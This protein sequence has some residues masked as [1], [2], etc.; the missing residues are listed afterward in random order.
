MN[1][2]KLKEQARSVIH[3]AEKILALVNDFP[4]KDI[5]P[6]AKLWIGDKDKFTFDMLAHT[7]D[8]EDEWANLLLN[9]L[10]GHDTLESLREYILGNWKSD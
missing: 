5:N 3:E 10:N 4:K 6:K 7:F 2:D 9:L 8:C 1:T